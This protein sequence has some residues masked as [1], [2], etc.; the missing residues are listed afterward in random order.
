MTKTLKI[1]EIL[2]RKL[3]KKKDEDGFGDKAIV[4]YL[5]YL[6]RDI[7]LRMTDLDLCQETTAA[8]LPLWMENFANNLPYIR[9]GNNLEMKVDN[10]VSNNLEE[11]AERE[12]PSIDKAPKGSAIVVGRG[13]TVF[14]KNHLGLLAESEY[15]GIIC[16]TDGMLIE[17][18]KKNIIPTLTTTVDGSPIIK[19]WYAHPLV[20]KHASQLNVALNVMVHH[21]VYK[22]LKKY[23]CNIY[24]FYPMFDDYRQ[25]T[26]WTKMQRM[27]TKSPHLTKP[28]QAIV[29]G[30][31]CG[32]SS[33]V[34]ATVLFKRSPVCLIGITFGYPKGTNLEKTPYFSSIMAE[35]HLEHIKY[36]Y[37]EIY[38]PFFKTKALMD[39]VFESYRMSFLAYNRLA[40]S[41]YHQWGGTINCS[42]GGTLFGPNINYMKFADFLKK[43]KH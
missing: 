28:V 40:P 27:M 22:I 23:G 37:R 42:E 10:Y 2:F 25:L 36:V 31:N 17:C 35:G 18:L 12:I 15:K 33:W 11:L 32:T 26:S 1:P 29:P 34:M 21:D 39:T 43:Y 4:D 38:H 7:K 20:K 16:A 6:T 14:T 24:W 30:G 8:L 19:K 13:P 41:W 3:H 9:F 5:N